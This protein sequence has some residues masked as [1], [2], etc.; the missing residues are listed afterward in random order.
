MTGYVSSVRNACIVAVLI[1]GIATARAQTASDFPREPDKSM[2][3]AH[4][5]FLK[6][7]L[8]KAAEHIAKAATDVRA[9]AKKVDKDAAKVLQKAG[10]DLDRLGAD[11][12]AGA[13]KSSD[14]LK[15]AFARVDYAVATAWHATAEQEQKAGHDSS[16]ALRGAASGLEGAAKWAGTKLDAGAQGAVD[17]VNTAGR[18]ARFG[19]EAA[20]KALRSLGDG[21]ADLGRKIAS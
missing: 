18:G 13:V 21:I 8:T 3:A 5:S 14:Q 9:Q 7:D 12:K 4:E 11:I 17:A 19:V 2:A 10:D 16:Q 1:A 6:G 15:Q 20:G